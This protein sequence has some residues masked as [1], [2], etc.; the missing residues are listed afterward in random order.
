MAGLPA[1]LALSRRRLDPAQRRQADPATGAH[2]HR[3]VVVPRFSRDDLGRQLTGKA[4]TDLVFV[5][6]AGTP[7]RVQNFRRDRFDRA[8]GAV[9][10]SGFTPHELPAHRRIPRHQFQRICDEVQPMLGH[11]SGQMTLDRYGHPFPD[12]L[13]AVADRWDT[14]RADQAPT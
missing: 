12:E 6:R 1:R 14:A 5:S 9:G 4:P 8:A 11:A 3:S 2:Q 13:D 7:L 10:F